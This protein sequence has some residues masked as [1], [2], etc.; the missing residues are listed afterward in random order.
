VNE[1]LETSIHFLLRYGYA[2]LF[3][4]VL[5]EQIGIPIPAVPVLLAMGALVGLGKFALSWA[6]FVT[7]LATLISDLIWYELGRR[8]GRS[9]LNLVCRVSLEPDYCV[10]RTEDALFRSG[11]RLLL[12]AKFVP[13]LN[14][15]APPLVAVFRMPLNQF[16]LWD[17]AGTLLWGGG[18]LGLGLLFR[19]ELERIGA[20]SVRFGAG[21]VALLI[22]ALMVYLAQKYYHRRKFLRQ[23]RTDR[24]TPEELKG[25][26]AAGEEVVV[27]DLRHPLDFDRDPAKLPGALR[28]LPDELER[29]HQEIPR[30]RDVVLYCTCPNEA[31]SARMALALRRRGVTKV[32]PLAGG[33]EAWRRSGYPV[34]LSGMPAVV[35]AR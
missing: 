27:V 34:E 31:T 7:L 19:T 30:D 26:M 16:L 1:A 29:N 8:R 11:P 2:I 10:R 32:R 13:G 4:V 23:L 21:A 14:L 20:L 3:V 24:I 15:A 12:F 22:A 33:F 28:L 25:K 18:F 17:A 6:L 5:A 35:G 9:V